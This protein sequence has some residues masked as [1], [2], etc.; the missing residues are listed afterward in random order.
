[1]GIGRREFIGTFAAVLASLSQTTSAAA[2]VVDRTYINRKLGLGFTTPDKWIFRDLKDVGE[3]AA[4]RLISEDDDELNT[5]FQSLTEA[6]L[7]LVVVSA[8]QLAIPEARFGPHEI[9]PVIS[10]HLEDTLPI[11]GRDPH[12]PFDLREHVAIDLDHF[13]ELVAG[14][15]LL[16]DPRRITLSNCEAIEYWATYPFLH[17]ALPTGCPVRERTIYVTQNPAIYGIRM[18]DYPERSSLLTHDF[19]GFVKTIRIM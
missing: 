5:I 1:M 4:G 19:D 7:P 10:V 16:K 11:R 6:H 3:M 2:A 13:H 18:C 12:L 8:P 15:R 14:F 17:E 9:A